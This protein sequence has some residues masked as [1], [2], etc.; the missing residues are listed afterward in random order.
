MCGAV[1]AATV[2]LIVKKGRIQAVY[3]ESAEGDGPV[4]A[5]YR[6]IDNIVK[7]T[8]TLKKTLKLADFSLKSVSVGKDAQGEASVSVEYGGHTI[9]GR[10]ASTDIIE[11]SIKSYLDALN[12]IAAQEYGR[13]QHG[14]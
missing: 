12:R 7:K 2:S 1:P 13:R 8:L 4:D 9:N 5:A 14:L 6:A 11:A 3:E 10:G